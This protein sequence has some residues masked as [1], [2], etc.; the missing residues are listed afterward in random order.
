MPATLQ[1]LLAEKQNCLADAEVT[2]DVLSYSDCGDCVE[3]V[4]IGN[5]WACGAQLCQNADLWSDY[6]SPTVLDMP[7]ALDGGCVECLTEND[8]DICMSW[9]VARYSCTEHCVLVCGAIQLH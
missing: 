1:A 4:K 8:A 6:T 9:C 3:D 2:A 5:R 7:T